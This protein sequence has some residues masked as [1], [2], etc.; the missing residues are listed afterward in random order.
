MARFLSQLLNTFYV[1]VV[2]AMLI[3][4]CMKGRYW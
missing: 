4:A 2:I 3:M 1:G